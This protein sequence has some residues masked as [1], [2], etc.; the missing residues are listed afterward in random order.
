MRKKLLNL[1]N[2]IYLDKPGIDSLYAQINKTMVIEERIQNT[3]GGNLKGKFGLSGKLKV[4]FNSDMGIEGEY[5]GTQMHE[6]V[7]E[8]AYEQKLS[9]IIELTSHLDN[10]CTNIESAREKC[11]GNA[12][13]VLINVYDEFF[14]RLCFRSHEV[15]EY[16]QKCGYLEFERGDTPISKD[17]LIE[18]NV[19]YDTYTYSDDYYK[20]CN[21]CRYRV[22]MS[23]SLDKMVTSYSG[24]SSHLAVAL[25]GGNGKIRLGV[26]GQIRNINDFYFQIKPFAVWW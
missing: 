16:I 25:R 1:R 13:F 10:Y 14:S 26:F 7:I 20:G 8:S 15:F 24:M 11:M 12:P 23:M 22:V 9:E 6:K 17:T 4:L 2:Y 19:P 3:D 21:E 5:H 18:Y